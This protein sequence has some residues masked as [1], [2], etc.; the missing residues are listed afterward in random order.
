MR[1][2]RVLALVVLTIFLAVPIASSARTIKG[3]REYTKAKKQIVR[4]KRDVRDFATLLAEMDALR[5]P[6]QMRGFWAVNA[7]LRSAMKHEYQ[8]ASKKIE[9]DPGDGDVTN[10]KKPQSAETSVSPPNYLDAAGDW[11]AKPG[12]DTVHLSRPELATKMKAIIMESD[13]LQRMMA[14]GEM[15]ALTRYRHLLGEFL[16]LMRADVEADA[17]ALESTSE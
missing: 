17:E 13:G 15:D 3:G 14:S 10:N 1:C 12:K 2:V 11:A 16:E 9:N 6:R 7:N 8:A 5:I 4:D